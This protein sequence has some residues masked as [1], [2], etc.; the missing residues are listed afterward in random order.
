[1]YFPHDMSFQYFF[2]DTYPGYF[3]QALPIALLVGTIYGILRWGTDRETPLLRKMFSC[4]FVCYL[5]GLICLVLGLDLMGNGWYRLFYHQ[6]SGHEIRFFSGVFDFVPDFFHHISSEVIGNLVMFLP[7]GV[8]YPLSK[9]HPTWKG[10]LCAGSLTVLAIEFLQ[11][12]FGR[13]F[14]LNDVI[15]NTLGILISATVFLAVRRLVKPNI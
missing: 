14:D 2:F 10:T 9:A 8:L 4:L 15:L 12:V 3:L 1:M 7:F 5:T 6:S 13:S 11:P